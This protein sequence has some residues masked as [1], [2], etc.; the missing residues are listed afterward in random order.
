MPSKMD[1]PTERAALP[2]LTWE[3]VLAWRMARQHLHR[4]APAT[5]ALA[6]AADLC[7]LHA[8]V[9]S[10]AE[11]TL[12]ARVDGLAPEAV[13]RMLWDDRSLVKTWAMRGTLH[14]L[15]AAELPLW[16][17]AQGVAKPRY[18]APSWQKAFGVSRAE[19]ETILAAMPAVLDDKMLTREELA[20]SLA[21]AAELPHL[22][23]RLRESRGTVLKPLAFAGALCFAPNA[24]RAVRFTRPDQ[25]L[26]G[27]RAIAPDEAMGTILRRYLHT[28]GPATREDIS[29]WFGAISPALAGR[30]LKQL[31]D[32]AVEVDLAGAPAWALPADLAEMSAMH[33]GGV[34][35]LL[36]AFDQYVVTAPRDEPEVLAAAMRDRVYRPQAWFSPVVVEDGRMI[37]VW[38]HERNGTK[39]TVAVEPFA[40]LSP[41]QKDRI[42]DEAEAL[43]AYLDGNLSLTFAAPA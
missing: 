6:V 22:E 1:Q 13:T 34:I 4:R 25:W 18:H 39:L 19:M 2:Q 14:L 20:A 33:P 35:R 36:P 8:Q 41:A 26:A 17:A 9:M 27:W 24:G 28:Y 16:V 43:A 40:R 15:P 30:L 3:N 32:D 29:R 42:V 7:G 11:L 37:G 10:S 23:D 21:A 12:W 38:R 31:G 5:A